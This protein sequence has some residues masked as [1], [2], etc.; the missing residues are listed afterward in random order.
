MVAMNPTILIVEDDASNMR[1]LESFLKLS[2]H[3]VATADNAEDALDYIRQQPPALVLLDVRM[4]GMDGLEMV[5]RIRADQNASVARTPLIAITANVMPGAE[6]EIIEAGCDGYI[7]KPIDIPL[8][9]SYLKR[10]VR[11]ARTTPPTAD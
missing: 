9:E 1:F 3:Q 11:N 5:R 6:S 10:F 7:P 8:L 4:P 2:G